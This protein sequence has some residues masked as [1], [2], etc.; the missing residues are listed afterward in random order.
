MNESKIIILKGK[1]ALNR[2]G[3]F[4]AAQTHSLLQALSLL[5]VAFPGFTA[6]R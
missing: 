2:A 3:Q 6:W 1:K 5:F 4:S